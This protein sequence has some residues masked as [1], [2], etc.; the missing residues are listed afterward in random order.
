MKVIVNDNVDN[1]KPFS[2]TITFDTREEL[3]GLEGFVTRFDKCNASRGDSG[4]YMSYDDFNKAV[5]SA[6]GDR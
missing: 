4:N 2:V 5:R 6:I 1:F 3:H